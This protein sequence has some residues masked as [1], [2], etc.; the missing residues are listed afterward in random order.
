[1]SLNQL[2]KKINYT[3]KDFL[4][5]RTALTHRSYLNEKDRDLTILEHNER[6]EFLGDA[7][8]ELCVTDFLYKNYADKEG[9]LTALR[10]SLVN[11]KL[12]GLVGQELELEN[13]ILLSSGEKAELGK[14]RLTIVADGVEALLGAMYL[15]GGIEP[16]NDFV[17]KFVLTKL[18]EIIKNSSW[19]DDKTV[20][21]EVSQKHFKVTPRYK[22][23]ETIGKDHEKTFRIAVVLG[24]ELTAEGI[25]KSK[26]E[27]ETNAAGNALILIKAKMELENQSETDK[28]IQIKSTMTATT[29]QITT[30]TT[31]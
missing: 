21:Q 17:D 12:I 19:K 29:T 23:M 4:L 3:F 27:A 14:A 5:L 13:L 7:V 10:A 26:Q 15:D 20:L 30:I 9:Y 22:V 2:Q 16:C 25:G 6:L 31:D 11:Y 1:M 18:E 24:N 28:E 8:L